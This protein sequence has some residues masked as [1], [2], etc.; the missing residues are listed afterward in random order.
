MRRNKE[1]FSKPSSQILFI[2]PSQFCWKCHIFFQC[3]RIFRSLIFIIR[4][5]MP[6]HITAQILTFRILFLKIFCF[7]DKAVRIQQPFS[8]QLIIELYTGPEWSQYIRI[9]HIVDI[10]IQFVIFHALHINTAFQIY[11]SLCQT[12]II[13]VGMQLRIVVS[14]HGIYRKSIFCLRINLFHCFQRFYVILIII[15]FRASNF[16][17]QIPSNHIPIIQYRSVVGFCIS[18]SY[19]RSHK[20]LY[21]FSITLE[22]FHYIITELHIF[23]ENIFCQCVFVIFQIYRMFSFQHAFYMVIID[24]YDITGSSTGKIKIQTFIVITF[25]FQSHVKLFFQILYNFRRISL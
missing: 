9:I 6:I 17:I 21:I 11:K 23:T 2:C 13:K 3:F 12:S 20:I 15:N 24:L 1:I 16:L 14:T 4:S 5:V 25:N 19:T 18:K 22:C 7:C 8:V 10:W